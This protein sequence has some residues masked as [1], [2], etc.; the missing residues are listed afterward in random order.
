VH[1]AFEY[2]S[3]S[4]D[5]DQPDV[6]YEVK[7]RRSD[8]MTTQRGILM[9]EPMDS[10]KPVTFMCEVQ[11]ALHEVRP[12][13]SQSTRLSQMHPI[14]PSLKEN[15]SQI[16]LTK[17]MKGVKR[18]KNLISCF[19]HLHFCMLWTSSIQNG[20]HAKGHLTA[21]KGGKHVV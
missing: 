12:N 15:L 5:V 6:R 14:Q 4:T 3:K 9:R 8:S 21:A 19:V 13:D 11:P 2:L 18:K 10:I 7:A 16:I 20:T 17:K 1:K